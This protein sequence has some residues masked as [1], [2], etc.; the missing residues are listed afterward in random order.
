M[1]IHIVGNIVELDDILFINVLE[2]K[3]RKN[4]RIY[5]VRLRLY[6]GDEFDLISSQSHSEALRY[7]SSLFSFLCEGKTSITIKNII[8]SSRLFS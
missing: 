8:E 1:L 7:M 2:K 4:K 6:S 5:V 3:Q